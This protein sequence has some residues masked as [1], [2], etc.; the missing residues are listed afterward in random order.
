MRSLFVAPPG[1]KLIIADFSHMELVVAACVVGETNML[2]A[3][4]AGEDLHK[5][6]GLCEWSND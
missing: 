5:V 1:S 6:C 3:L 4:H 2:A